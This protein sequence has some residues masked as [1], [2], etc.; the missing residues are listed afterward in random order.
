M[1]SK[2]KMEYGPTISQMVDKSMA[3]DRIENF[4]YSLNEPEGV[5]F[6]IKNNPAYSFKNIN[7]SV[8]IEKQDDNTPN[9]PRELIDHLISIAK[10][11]L[12]KDALPAS[13]R[14]VTLYYG[15]SKILIGVR[16][17]DGSK[18]TIHFEPNPP[19]GVYYFKK[20]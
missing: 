15:G 3:M 5:E 1:N 8:K 16:G 14:S 13:I 19:F 20:E 12:G 6:W 17:A 9:L 7:E 10:K 4:K 11:D 2:N 18:T